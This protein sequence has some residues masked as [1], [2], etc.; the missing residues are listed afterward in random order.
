MHDEQ[1]RGTWSDSEAERL[2]RAI[3]KYSK[4][5]VFEKGTTLKNL[6]NK[7]KDF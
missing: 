6:L 1:Q 2:L 7:G 3:L 5:Y 4:Q